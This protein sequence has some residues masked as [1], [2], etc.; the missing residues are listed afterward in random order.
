VSMGSIRQYMNTHP[1]ERDRILYHNKSY[2]FFNIS[3]ESGNPKGNLNVSLTPHRSIATDT[4]AFPKAALGFMTSELPVFDENWELK[5]WQPFSRFVVNQDTGGAIKGPDRVDLFW[6]NGA[7]AAKSA[8][9][10]RR[11]GKLYFL[12]AKKEIISKISQRSL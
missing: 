9:T 4:E 5:E 6:G 1:R 10:M 11:H 3:E 2:T 12:I 7:L 8:G